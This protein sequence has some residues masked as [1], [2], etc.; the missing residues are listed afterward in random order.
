M[1]PSRS[2]LVHLRLGFSILLL[3]VYLFA[4]SQVPTV[5]FWPAIVAFFT[6]HFLVYPASN[7]YNSY[8]DKDEESIALLAKPPKVDIS[9]YYFSLLM[10]FVAFLLAFFVGWQFALAVVVY[11]ILSKLYSHPAT[12]LKKYPVVSF[13]VVF[14]FQGAFIYWTTYAAVSGTSIFNLWNGHF[15]EA[16]IICSCLIGAS[17]PLTQIY[18]HNEDSRRGDRTLSILLGY[19]GSFAFAGC[20]FVIGTILCFYYWHAVNQ[21][22]NFYIFLSCALPVFIFFCYWLF[23]V[24]KTVSNAN[25]KNAMR[26]SFISAGCMLVYFGYL[27]FIR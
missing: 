21:P 16:G 17:Y 5:H 4:L 19:R 18:Q 9:L 1:F 15:L 2:A 10:D 7:A 14:I 6:W 27:A 25:F 22:V 3:P 8:F 12:R 13:L 11:G 26:M 23:L 20:L 24:I